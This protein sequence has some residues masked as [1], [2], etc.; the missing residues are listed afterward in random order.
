MI[1]WCLIINQLRPA[2]GSLERLARE[3]NTCPVHLR[4]ISRGEVN[5][6]KYSVGVRL[7]EKYN[8]QRAI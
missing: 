6:P 1:D 3:L 2:S 4:R 7:L 5:E 8:K